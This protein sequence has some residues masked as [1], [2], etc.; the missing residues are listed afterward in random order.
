[1]QEEARAPSAP[2]PV[3][4][5]EESLVTQIFWNS[6]GTK[7]GWRKKRI[8]LVIGNGTGKWSMVDCGPRNKSSKYNIF[9]F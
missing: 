7:E 8:A 4:P 1:M 5:L 6:V 3:V 2:P 9:I